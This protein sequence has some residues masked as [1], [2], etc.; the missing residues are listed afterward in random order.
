MKI[1]DQ[2][3][4][5]IERLKDQCDVDD[6][7]IED[8]AMQKLIR[9]K[10]LATAASTIAASESQLMQQ[11]FQYLKESII[12]LEQMGIDQMAAAMHSIAVGIA[13]IVPEGQKEDFLKLA[14]IFSQ[15]ENNVNVTTVGQSTQHGDGNT[16][17][18]ASEKK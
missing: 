2:H 18:D 8:A 12:R 3:K 6:D 13:A 16:A 5:I 14:K 11:E 15:R 10:V 4:A 17:V 7:G 9:A 1:T